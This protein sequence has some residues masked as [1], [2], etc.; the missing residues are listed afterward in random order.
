MVYFLRR[1]FEAKDKLALM[2]AQTNTIGHTIKYLLNDNGGEFDSP[3]IRGLLDSHGI[4]H[5]PWNALL[6]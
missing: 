6:S 3:F 5:L 1:K 4:S 2:I